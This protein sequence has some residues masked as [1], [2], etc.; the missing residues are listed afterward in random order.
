[1]YKHALKRVF[2]VLFGLI[3]SI[4]LL[5]GCD[6]FNQK[7]ITITKVNNVS[8]QVDDTKNITV[9]TTPGDVIIKAVSNNPS[10][11]TV[12]VNKNIL[13]INGKAEGEAEIT[14]TATKSGYKTASLKFKI[15]VSKLPSKP[16]I[17]SVS[18]LADIE[19]AYRTSFE[20]I[21]LP[22]NVEVTLDDQTKQTLEVEWDEGNYDGNSTGTYDL[23]GNLILVEG[24]TNTNE[25]KAKINVIVPVAATGDVRSV[26]TLEAK[27][28]S[29][30]T[31]FVDLGL[32]TQVKVK[33]DDGSEICLDV[34][35]DCSNYDGTV[36]GATYVIEGSLVLC[37]GI[38][39]TLNLNVTIELTVNIPPKIIDLTPSEGTYRLYEC[40]NFLLSAEDDDEDHLTYRWK[41]NEEEIIFYGGED[42]TDFDHSFQDLGSHE[43]V[44]QASDGFNEIEKMLIFEV[45]A[46]PEITSLTAS[47]TI[48]KI[49]EEI[50]IEVEAVDYED[51]A[52]TYRWV[53]NY[54]TI[55]EVESSSLTWKPTELGVYDF[56]V[57][58]SD[59]HG[60]MGEVY[61]QIKIEVVEN[62]I[63]E[64]KI[65]TGPQNVMVNQKEVIF[66]AEYDHRDNNDLTVHWEVDGGTIIEGQGTDEIRW[67]APTEKG[68]FRLTFVVNDGVTEVKKTIDI[69]VKEPEIE[70]YGNEIVGAGQESEFRIYV[71]IG[72][73]ADINI[74]VSSTDGQLK[75]IWGYD[76]RVGYL[77]I[78][79]HEIGFETIT[80]E[81]TIDGVD[82]APVQKQIEVIENSAPVIN[83]FLV[84]EDPI[85]KEKLLILNVNENYNF[86][87]DVEDDQALEEL[88]IEWYF[89]DFSNH[90]FINQF[91]GMEVFDFNYGY[92]SIVR[93]DIS[94]KDGINEV[95][96]YI[97][98]IFDDGSVN[99]LPH[100][101]IV[102]KIENIIADFELMFE[103]NDL[104]IMSEHFH[105]D[106]EADLRTSLGDTLNN[107][108]INVMKILDR[109]YIIYDAFLESY[110][111]CCL[112]KLE[113]STDE[114]L[115]GPAIMIFKEDENGVIK[116]F[117]LD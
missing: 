22:D 23:A 79:P 110:T 44:V 97:N 53:K 32:P 92:R 86:K 73:E 72:F 4:A 115:H 82:F 49:D 39:N 33:L 38:T 81:V 20:N 63:P 70:I 12:T 71:D 69:N 114:I 47:E 24:I 15:I 102:N 99:E 2:V 103:Q 37:T 8:L 48:I 19:V 55:E 74:F 78:A 106:T 9:T 107:G 113:L 95:E 50:T 76:N 29:Y 3:L 85:D 117:S 96:D 51:D 30:A 108:V 27:K 36:E 28:V 40:F 62:Y 58:V 93:V 56:G 65:I 84:N 67:N 98:I 42:P 105:P 35:W 80:A 60:G 1:M 34:D 54:V 111:V 57:Y 31:E 18:L 21:G 16:N 66:K 77:W 7:P 5:S 109:D 26:E 45:N 10:I 87:I 6:L 89:N 104:E 90:D 101:A 75:K 11:A 14:I 100:I 41:D 46:Y 68:A 88:D 17:V 25:L 64:I 83:N 52:L 43:I 112:A 61:D 59:G 94:V 91:I 116:L 13:T